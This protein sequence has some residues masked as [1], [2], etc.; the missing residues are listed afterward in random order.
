MKVARSK[1]LT[2]TRA[3]RCWT[4]DCQHPYSMPSA[5]ERLTGQVLLPN[6]TTDSRKSGVVTSRAAVAVEP[7]TLRSAVIVGLGVVGDIGLFDAIF[8]PEV[9]DFLARKSNWLFLIGDK[10]VYAVVDLCVNL[11][12]PTGSCHSRLFTRHPESLKIGTAS[13]RSELA[14]V[15]SWYLCGVFGERGFA[16][17]EVKS[18][19]EYLRFHASRHRSKWRQERSHLRFP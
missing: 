12:M 9:L 13:C 3:F 19:F 16:S 14:V 7:L 18:P 5:Q 2:L 1:C 11:S 8:A 6:L 17:R 10:L 4:A 15:D